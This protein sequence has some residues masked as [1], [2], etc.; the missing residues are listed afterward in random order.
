MYIIKVKIMENNLI[1]FNSVT[2]AMR[3]REILGKNNVFSRLIR[4]PLN[5]KNRS[6][7]YSLFVKSDFAK[8]IEILS[9]NGIVYIGTAAVDAE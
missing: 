4:T 8:A 9:R 5:L 1:M 2:L 3:A 7:G 6:C